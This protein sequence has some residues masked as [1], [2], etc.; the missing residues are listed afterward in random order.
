MCLF[1]QQCNH[2][3]ANTNL[4]R[5]QSSFLSNHPTCIHKQTNNRQNHG[6]RVI[7]GLLNCSEKRLKTQKK[8]CWRKSICL[9]HTPMSHMPMGA[10]NSCHKIC[11]ALVLIPQLM[12]LLFFVLFGGK[13][14]RV[15]KL[16]RKTILCRKMLINALNGFIYSRKTRKTIGQM[17]REKPHMKSCGP[18]K[19]LLLQFDFFFWK[20]IN[21]CRL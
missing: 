10:A 9:S 12:V 21:G 18:S 6:L 4:N 17:F 7:Y 16:Q 1:R 20:I 19:F 2:Q 5:M 11:T 15:E 3:F 8:N 13:Y 14:S